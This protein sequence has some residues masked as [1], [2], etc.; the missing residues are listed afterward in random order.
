MPSENCGSCGEE[1]EVVDVREEN[2]DTIYELE[3]GHT[4]IKKTLTEEL[5]LSESIEGSDTEGRRRHFKSGGRRAKIPEDDKIVLE[6]SLGYT[7]I[8]LQVLTS[9]KEDSIQRIL[10]NLSDWM[11]NTNFE[12]I[13]EAEINLALVAYV[14]NYRMSRQDVDNIAKVVIDAL[15]NLGNGEPYLISDDNQIRR[16][17][18]EKREKVEDD[19][20]DTDDVLISFRRHGPEKEMILESPQSI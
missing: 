3:C 14:D 9:E 8:L 16:L 20:F 2:H 12:E 13:Q 4:L 10:S 7:N 17:L 11:D 6:D 15:Q 18:V 19:E 1:K 5:N